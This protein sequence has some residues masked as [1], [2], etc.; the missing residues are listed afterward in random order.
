MSKRTDAPVYQTWRAM[1]ARCTNPRAT[2]YPY[3][4]GRGIAVCER[5]LDAEKAGM[6]LSA[7]I[8]FRCDTLGPR[9]PV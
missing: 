8:R 6:T 5:W 7:W 1:I 9:Y 4:G 2:N 3:Y